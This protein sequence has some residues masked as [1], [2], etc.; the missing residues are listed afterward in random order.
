MRSSCSGCARPI[1]VC[2]CDVLPSAPLHTHTQLLVLQHPHETKHKLA[3]VPILARCL[4]QCHIVV[5]RRLHAT[6]SLIIRSLTN[7]TAAQLGGDAT[8]KFLL[9][10]PGPD[11]VQLQTWYS[12]LQSR[13]VGQDVKRIGHEEGASPC[14]MQILEVLYYHF[15]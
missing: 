8:P 3:T 15:D 13:E 2:L 5:G 4:Q 10:F 1:S 14:S 12:S 11:A 6:S 9:L 7:G